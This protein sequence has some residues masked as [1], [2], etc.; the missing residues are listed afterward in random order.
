MDHPRSRNVHGGWFSFL[1]RLDL[2]NIEND[3][4]HST[5][6]VFLFSSLNLFG[7]I[8]KMRGFVTAILNGHCGTLA[9]VL[10]DARAFGDTQWMPCVQMA[11]MRSGVRFPYQI[12]SVTCAVA[13]LLTVYVV[14]H[15]RACSHSPR[16]H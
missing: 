14:A 1:E 4:L 5:G 11:F 6:R 7:A 10:M 8:S 3:P 9:F 16:R 13:K 12:I 15:A 2:F